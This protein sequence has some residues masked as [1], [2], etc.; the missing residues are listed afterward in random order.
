MDD[1]T[2]AA[3]V[4]KRSDFRSRV[5]YW[6]A[7]LKQAEAVFSRWRKRSVD[8]DKRYELEERASDTYRR[9]VNSDGAFNILWS[10]VQTL[11]PTIYGRE[12]IPVVQRRHRDADP[13][14]RIAS[15]T[16]QRAI[17]TE[18]EADERMGC[19]MDDVL[20]RATLD[21]LLSARGVAW[22][23]YEPSIGGTNEDPV[24]LGEGCPV[25]FVAR[26]EFLHAPK[27]TWAEVVKSGWVARKV[28]MTREEGE[29][30]FGREFKDVPLKHMGMG[31]E[32]DERE[33]EVI[34]RAGV[35]EI[36]DATRREVLWINRDHDKVL[37]QKPDHMGLEG[38]FPCPKPAF[39]TIGNRTLVPTPDYRQYAVLAQEMDRQTRRINK[40]TGA[41]RVAGVYDASVEGLGSLLLE[42]DG[43][44]QLVPI[45]NMAA[46]SGK[47]S[48]GGKLDGVVQWLPI[49]AVAKALLGLYDARDRTKQTMYEVSGIADVLRGV[50]DPRE[51][52]GQSQI[53]SQH[54]G[55]RIDSRRKV[56]EVLARDLIR[57]KAEIIAEHYSPE[58]IREISGFDQMPEVQRL[59]RMG[60]PEMVENVFLQAVGLLKD[61][62]LRGFRIE[63]ETNSTVMADDQA[64]KEARTEFL[65]TMG[66]FLERM[67]PVAQAMPEFAPLAAESV[68]FGIRAFPSGRGLESAFEDALERL[69]QPENQPQPEAGEGG[70]EDPAV[71]AEAQAQQA[72][73][74]QAGAQAGAQA[75]MAGAQAAQATSAAKVQESQARLAATRAS[76]EAAIKKAE[77]E[78]A[79]TQAEAQAKVMT[80]QA[81]LGAMRE[82]LEMERQRGLVQ[83]AAGGATDAA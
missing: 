40:L 55:K 7:E 77:A 64:E 6:D 8:I 51:K 39:G 27:R 68:L 70:G 14:G 59:G 61:E 31:G 23:R 49:E 37:D 42:S 75:K 33:L 53:K 43:R 48:G 38:F 76:A 71:T 12:P 19:G 79:V 29:A 81:E 26:D 46:L 69:Q 25:D 2:A 21:L 36:W 73:A 3:G 78:I 56:I 24:V 1:T 58:R 74:A 34:G 80:L 15:D 66:Q 22:V 4:E 11:L 44:D 20:L 82:K 45:T 60:G 30:R 52:L 54:A 62:K 18:M 10:N 83:V 32:D 67:L 13:V 72:Q 41:L 63:I 5:A 9:S 16:L 35:W 65:G 47:G 17:S 28:D 50:V 57:R